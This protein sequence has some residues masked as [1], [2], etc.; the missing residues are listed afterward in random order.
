MYPTITLDTCILNWN[1][2]T[3]QNRSRT[4]ARTAWDRTGD[5]AGQ[6][7]GHGTGQDKGHDRTE[8]NTGQ[9]T[10]GAAGQG[11]ATLDL[12]GQYDLN[13]ISLISE[14]N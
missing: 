8:D 5:M 7:P 4:R 11:R 10:G 6:G 12:A 1:V 13:A 2:K 14:L 3:F 9:K